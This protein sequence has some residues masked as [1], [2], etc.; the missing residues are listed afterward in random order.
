M[1]VSATAV[2]ERIMTICFHGIGTPTRSL[3]PGEERFWIDKARYR[4]L[5]DAICDH[6]RTVDITFD[7]G[8][9][10]DADI[11]LP[12]LR[13][14]Y[15][16][17]QFFII[18]DRIDRPGSLA[19][20]QLLDLADAG[21]SFGTHGASHRPWPELAT[22]GLLDDELAASRGCLQDLLGQEIDHA[23]F[24][25]GLYDRRVL[26]VLRRNGIRR[27]Y[28]VDEGTSPR[29]SWLRTRYSV[30]FSD[31][32]ESI[33]ALLSNPY[34]FVGPRTLHRMKLTVKRWM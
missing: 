24:P 29:D 1:K 26:T 32:P 12:P 19:S 21:M 13:D 15:L 23:A 25:R 6:P 18:T 5:L 3:E 33:S 31:T 11:G 17:A 27:A 14:R 22:Q 30:I 2:D 10:S 28:S 9:A 20:G 34:L 4:D 8:N 16:K 7:D